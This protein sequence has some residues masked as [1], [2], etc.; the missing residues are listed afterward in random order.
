MV[1]EGM[2]R[3]Q[4]QPRRATVETVDGVHAGVKAL[5]AVAMYE[6]VGDRAVVA[7]V[8]RMHDQARRLVDDH[9]IL[10]LVDDGELQ[11]FG[12]HVSGL[13]G[14]EPE[15]QVIASLDGGIHADEPPL[16]ADAVATLE[17]S[18]EVLGGPELKAEDVNDRQAARSRF[19]DVRV[20]GLGPSTGGMGRCGAIGVRHVARIGSFR[21]AGWPPRGWASDP[22]PGSS[23]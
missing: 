5:L 10:V 1:R 17:L 8:G 22:V 4:H 19:H 2:P 14:V 3:K 11:G 12:V 9:D 20:P 15:F 16:E 6:P 13:G 7:P 21:R 23:G 18:D